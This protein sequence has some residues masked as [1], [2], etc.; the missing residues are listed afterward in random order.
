MLLES[1]DCAY[2][3]FFYIWH[4]IEEFPFS[5]KLRSYCFIKENNNTKRKCEGKHLCSAI[6][7]LKPTARIF[8]NMIIALFL[9]RLKERK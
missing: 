3:L 9:K 1:V 2:F 6:L 7:S 4:W 8:L 5:K